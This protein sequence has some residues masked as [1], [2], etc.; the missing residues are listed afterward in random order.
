MR[1][2]P[3]LQSILFTRDGRSVIGRES[4]GAVLMWNLHPA[5]LAL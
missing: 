2:T 3:I 5:V 1:A 4:T